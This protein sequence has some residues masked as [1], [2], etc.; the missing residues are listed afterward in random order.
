M[1]PLTTD[2]ATAKQAEL[3]EAA[4]LDRC[5]GAGA[6]RRIRRWRQAETCC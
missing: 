4:R 3:R 6:L 2:I 1:H 5:C